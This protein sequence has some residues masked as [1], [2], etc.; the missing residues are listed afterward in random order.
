MRR[1]ANGDGVSL[2]VDENVQ[3]IDCGDGSTRVN[4][5]KTTELYALNG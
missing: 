2:W 5:L 4:I 1:I 3:K